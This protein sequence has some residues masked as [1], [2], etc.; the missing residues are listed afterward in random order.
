MPSRNKCLNVRELVKVVER[1]KT[2][3]PFLL[4]FSCA[5]SLSMKENPVWK[6]ITEHSEND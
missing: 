4:L 5:S 1:N 6:K 2:L 3:S